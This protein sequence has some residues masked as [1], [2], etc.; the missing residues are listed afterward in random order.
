VLLDRVR[1]INSD[2]VV[3]S[4][5]RLDAQVVV[6]KIDVE[7]RVDQAI[8]DEL[9]DDASHLVTIEFYDCAYDLNLFHAEVLLYSRE[10]FWSLG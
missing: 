7:V 2:L 1:C 4:V 3:S 8:L 6:L 5:T 10:L 9:P